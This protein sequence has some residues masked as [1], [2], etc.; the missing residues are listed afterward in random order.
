MKPIKLLLVT[1]AIFLI[2]SSYA[3]QYKFIAKDK[4]K[5]TK[6]CVLAGNNEIKPLKK[7]VKSH[8]AW[9]SY[10]ESEKGLVNRVFCNNLHIANFAKKYNANETFDYLKKYTRKHN[11]DKVPTVTIKDIVARTSVNKSAEEIILVY[12]GR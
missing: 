11:L 2:N 9:S 3:V 12:V 4:S 7:A 5:D 1:A 10:R 8:K 6:M